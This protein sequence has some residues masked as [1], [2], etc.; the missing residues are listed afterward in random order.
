[1]IMSGQ[2]SSFDHFLKTPHRTRHPASPHHPPSDIHISEDQVSS[3]HEDGFLVVRNVLNSDLIKILNSASKDVRINKTLHCEMAYYNGPPIF[4]KVNKMC[5]F[6]SL[7]LF[8]S[9]ILTSVCGLTRFTMVF[10]MGFTSLLLDTWPRD[11]WGMLVSGFRTHSPWGAPL[12]TTQFPSNYSSIAAS[13]YCYKIKCWASQTW[14][15]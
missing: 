7:H 13:I 1:M 11:W 12:R 9:S 6:L 2:K 4:H 5:H 15:R 14:H 10:V 8:H 3:F